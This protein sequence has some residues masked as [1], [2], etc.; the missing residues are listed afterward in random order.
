MQLV[1]NSSETM[2]T[3]TL[4]TFVLLFLPSTVVRKW[5]LPGEIH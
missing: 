1:V 3:L 4:S 5:E 2:V